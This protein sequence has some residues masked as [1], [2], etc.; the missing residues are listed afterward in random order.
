MKSKKPKERHHH[1]TPLGKT[2]VQKVPQ[3]WSLTLIRRGGRQAWAEFSCADDKALWN[4]QESTAT[5]WAANL[6]GR[7]RFLSPLIITGA[8]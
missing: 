3:I 1:T 7:A 2:L 6:F 4:T 8:D 5:R